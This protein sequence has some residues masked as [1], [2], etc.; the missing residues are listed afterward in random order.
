MTEQSPNTCPA[1]LARAQI[2]LG[3]L[4]QELAGRRADQQRLL[5][6]SNMH[7]LL[8]QIATFFS[9]R[10]EPEI[11]IR[12]KLK[13]VGDF[14]NAETGF[15]LPLKRNSDWVRRAVWWHQDEDPNSDRRNQQRHFQTAI[16]NF[17][18]R[19]RVEASQDILQ[20]N[21]VIAADLRAHGLEP[22]L[23]FPISI[24]GEI[25]GILG[26]E[27]RQGLSPWCNTD[28]S[29]VR[30]LGEQYARALE[31][32][33]RD[34]ERQ[35]A[36]RRL[37]EA[38]ALAERANRSKSDFLARMSHEIRSPMSAIVGYTQMLTRG[39]LDEQEV[40][41]IGANISRNAQHLLSLINDILD[42]SKIEAGHIQLKQSTHNIRALVGEVID[43]MRVQ[44]NEKLLDLFCIIEEDVPESMHTDEL[45]LRQILI[46]L[47]GNAVK[48]TDRGHVTV[49]IR[50][51][52]S[53]PD[54]LTISVADTGIGIVHSDLPR[55][56]SPFSQADGRGYR[57]GTGLGLSIVKQLLG[58]MEGDIAVRSRPGRGSVF[59]IRL[60]LCVGNLAACKEQPKSAPTHTPGP[61]PARA[62]AGKRVLLVDDGEDNRRILTYFLKEAG[63]EVCCAE[64]G[65]RAVKQVRTAATPFD[66][67][68]MDMLMPGMDGYAATR[69]LRTQ[70]ISTPIVA[71]TAQAMVDDRAKCL[72]AGCDDYL[73]KPV[74]P[75]R[76]VKTVHDYCVAKVQ[77]LQETAVAEPEM[78]ENLKIDPS[79]LW[80]HPK[81]KYIIAD[82]VNA[83]AGAANQLDTAI[84]EKDRGR[85]LDLS[86]RYHGNGA[87]FGYPVVSEDAKTLENHLKTHAPLP[88]VLQAAHRLVDDLRFIHANHGRDLR[89]GQPIAN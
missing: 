48:Y 17:L 71:L 52:L 47:I 29:L 81:L 80:E 33:A 2:E 69:T 66:L 73:A 37:M 57:E 82:Y 51:D 6:L 53:H 77:R 50:R 78:S 75:E 32:V 41:D 11:G 67:I 62:L 79:P 83:M 72:D 39:N 14:L 49:S 30:Q 84:R 46:N 8:G 40:E 19:E 21:P 89:E 1:D 23:L 58:L 43:L 76:L 10:E 55:I 68:L 70:G 25:H 35:V 38:A 24:F 15:V 28:S 45:R 88:S 26:F 60:P 87:S 4:K 16:T 9:G 59:S 7:E 64:N 13:C 61:V 22:L 12:E 3:S 54:Q 44:A 5:R 85:L 20:T 63:A 36:A 42:L 86:H 56:F 74:A 31:R 27:H 65:R 18:K 34:Q